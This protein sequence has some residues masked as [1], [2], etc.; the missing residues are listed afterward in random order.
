MLSVYLYR[1]NMKMVAMKE[2]E[3]KATIFLAAMETPVRRFVRDR[4]SKNVTE[5]IKEQ[6][7]FLESNLNFTIIRVV[8]Q[9][10]QGE[11]LDHTRQEKIGE[12]YSPEEL[13]KVIASG[14]PLIKHQ[15][16]TLKLVP[17]QPEIPVIEVIYPISKGSK[18]GG[19]LAVIKII[20]DVRG[21]L[22]L[23]HAEYKRFSR[24]IFLGFALAS[25]LLVSG[26]LYFLRRQ[27]ITPVLSVIEGSAMVAS[28]NL[29]PRLVPRGSNEISYLMQSF[30]HMVDGLKQRDQMRQSL[31]LA[32]EVQQNLL[33]K[34]VPNFEGLDIAGKSIYCDETGG[35]YYD[36]IG[37]DEYTTEKI[38]IVI[39][40][41]SGHGISS[42]LLM[43]TAR[44]FLLQRSAL[45][46]SISQ[47]V[48][49]VNLQLTRDVANSGSFMSMFY[50]VIDK[51]CKGLKWVRAGHDP[52]ICYDPHDD[53]ISELKGDGISLGIDENWLYEENEKPNLANGQIIV[54]G[55]DG[56]WEARNPQ[57]E[58]F[59]KEAI[60]TIIR[61]NAN[62]SAN[63]LL[64]TIVESLNN[65]QDT[66]D[67]EDDVTLIVVKILPTF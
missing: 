34:D 53:A 46:G 11:I 30:N 44:A 32:M 19:V 57:G 16:K 60:Y 10:S 45:P 23:I 67:I 12:S 2:V 1:E 65:F 8:V 17:G 26:T 63:S 40:D 47:I 3:N 4:E 48:S 22:E 31:E 38:G 54:L 18:Q 43:A 51:T 29:E 61:E 24:R 27:I 49:D 7:E 20:L 37:F 6:A 9:D 41:V 58:M 66:F 56:I 59:G 14:R 50:M 13:Q 35:D 15:V 5:L 42:A 25:V 36:F 33:P 39:G 21:T 52:A 64:N 55:T 62:L 28:G